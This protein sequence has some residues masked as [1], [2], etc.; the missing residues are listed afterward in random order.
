[1][2]QLIGLPGVCLMPEG[3]S[4]IDAMRGDS[5]IFLPSLAFMFQGLMPA[6]NS[7][8]F[9]IPESLNGSSRVPKLPLPRCINPVIPSCL[10]PAGC[11]SHASSGVQ[12]ELHERTDCADPVDIFLVCP[13][14][15]GGASGE[16]REAERK[17]GN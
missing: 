17:R 12:I 4:Q 7:N 10:S 9:P 13:D 11:P 8:E 6:P 2:L 15:P 5:D 1:M 3:E 14:N 16:K